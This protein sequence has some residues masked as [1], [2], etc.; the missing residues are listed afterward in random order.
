MVTIL[1]KNVVA[2]YSEQHESGLVLESA[3]LSHMVS[4][5][6]RWWWKDEGRLTQRKSLLRAPHGRVVPT[7]KS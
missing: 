2:L 4:I 7:G 6:K 3:L 1:A 5:A